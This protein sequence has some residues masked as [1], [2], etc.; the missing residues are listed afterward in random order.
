MTDAQITELQEG[1]MV[2]VIGFSRPIMKIV[3]I[4]SSNKMANVIWFSG[5]DVM[6]HAIFRLIDLQLIGEVL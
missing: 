2:T 5:D 6:Q 4:R 1:A 3:D